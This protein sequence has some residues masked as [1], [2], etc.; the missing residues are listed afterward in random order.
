MTD[1][2]TLLASDASIETVA[3]HLDAQDPDERERQAN[4]LSGR[5]QALLWAV[6]GTGPAVDLAHFVP[7]SRGDLE[8]VHHPGRNT[9]PSLRYFQM[10]EKRFCRPRGE[11]ARLFGYNASNAWFVTPG[12]FVAYETAG[13]EEWQGR[14][15]VVID[16]HLVP[17]E[18]VPEAWPAVVPNSVGLQRFVYHRTRD[19]MRRVSSHVSIGR[20]AKEDERGDRELDFWFTLCRRDPA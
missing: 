20:A 15:A 4:D 6:A 11:R 14:G 9:I 8:A 19:F 17:A 2:R 3:A 16:Y 18:E 10:F 5:E 1:L 7:A 12:Y 13:R